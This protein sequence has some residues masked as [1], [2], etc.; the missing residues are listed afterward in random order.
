MSG[1]SAE[2]LALR[3]P[4]DHRSRDPGLAAALAVH[5]AAHDEPAIVDLGCGTG[6][7]LRATAPLL[8]IR[9]RWTLV[10]HDLRLLDAARDALSAWADE[11]STEDGKLALVKSSRRMLVS[12]R[13][14][15]LAADLD[16][17]LGAG[18][19][20]V[21]ASALFD[22]CSPGFIARFVAA[23]ASRKAA[24]YTTLTYDGMQTWSP[25]H[26]ADDA[27]L[28]A[29]LAHQKADKGLGAAAG[30]DAPDVLASALREAG[31][32]VRE[33]PSPWRLDARDA[34]LIA[35]LAAGFADAVLET[36]SLDG[37]VVRAWR[38]LQRDGAT[39]GHRD[40]LA[41]LPA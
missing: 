12:F 18:C 40:T 21:T 34:R 3:E 15:D 20:L 39:V 33:A 8:G 23:L 31:Y 37:G 4:V 19:D 9:Q 24:F 29:F 14:A 17:A 32:R 7:N 26:A 41:V 35:E 5:L 27:M 30:A 36:S 6:S 16:L 25:P 1:F 22:L 13:H 10:D 28:R 38:Q 11:T 2:W